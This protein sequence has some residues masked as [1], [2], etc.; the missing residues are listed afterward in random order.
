MFD[1]S[2]LNNVEVVTPE[3]E[4]KV[5]TVVA[6]VDKYPTEGTVLRVWANGNIFPSQ[7]L[8]TKL[9]LEYSDNFLHS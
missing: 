3:K 1:F 2:F 7:E 9:N 4:T 5:R 8:V 6:K